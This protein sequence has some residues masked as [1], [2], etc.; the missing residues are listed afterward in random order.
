MK[1]IHELSGLCNFSVN[2]KLFQSKKSRL[3]S[4]MNSVFYFGG[5]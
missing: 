2:L 3:K 1:D 5:L 4:K